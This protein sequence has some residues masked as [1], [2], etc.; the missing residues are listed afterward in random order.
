MHPQG[1]TE[2]ELHPEGQADTIAPNTMMTINGAGIAS[3]GP[4]EVQAADW[5]S[6]RKVSSPLNNLPFPHLGHRQR[7][8][9]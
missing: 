2:P 4:P 9:A 7:T 8:A 1:R 5:T 6:G 3:V